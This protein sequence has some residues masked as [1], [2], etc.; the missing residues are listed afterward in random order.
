VP[1]QIFVCYFSENTTGLRVYAGGK[2]VGGNLFIAKPESNVPL[3]AAFGNAEIVGL[4]WLSSR[5]F[6]AAGGQV[7]FVN[8]ARPTK[9]IPRLACWLHEKAPAAAGAFVIQGFENPRS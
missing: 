1:G 5:N 4:K 6:S 2:I 8:R 9:K 7:S 3:L